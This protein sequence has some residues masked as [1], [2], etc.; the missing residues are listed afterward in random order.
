MASFI[1]GHKI[2]LQL[3]SNIPAVLGDVDRQFA[4]ANLYRLA[5]EAGD[6]KA[7]PPAAGSAVDVQKPCIAELELV[8]GP[9][10]ILQGRLRELLQEW[11]DNPLL[12]QLIAICDRLLGMQL[13]GGFHHNACGSV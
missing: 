1:R 11:P 4:G 3:L 13:L 10:Q 5:L 7:P 12:E 6:L 8:I 9:V 2:A